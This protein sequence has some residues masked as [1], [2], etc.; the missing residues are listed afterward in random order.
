MYSRS[1]KENHKTNNDDRPLVRKKNFM[2]R[3]I[4]H[5]LQFSTDL[6][7]TRYMI[8]LRHMYSYFQKR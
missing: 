1:V 3:A 8:I 5:V 4:S 6:Y 2:E 7:L